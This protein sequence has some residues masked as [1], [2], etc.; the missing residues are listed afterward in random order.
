MEIRLPSALAITSRSDTDPA[1]RF[2]T[3]TP[4]CTGSPICGIG[5]LI[6]TSGANVGSGE[7][8]FTLT[9]LTAKA[10]GCQVL[11]PP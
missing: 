11:L 9:P 8:S 2:S 6:V 7:R 3:V 1:P 10:Y 4:I 5:G